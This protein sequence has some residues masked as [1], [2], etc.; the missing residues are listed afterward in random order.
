ME[1]LM[2]LIALCL[3]LILVS[4]FWVYRQT[5]TKIDAINAQLIEAKT[6]QGQTTQS[7]GHIQ[8]S[9]GRLTEASR[10]MEEVGKNIASLSDSPRGTVGFCQPFGERR[11]NRG[12]NCAHDPR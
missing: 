3:L 1:I 9:L 4:V 11:N 7:F 5:N 6:L 8:S 12:G 2:G 10:H